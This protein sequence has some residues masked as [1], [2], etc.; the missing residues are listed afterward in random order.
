VFCTLILDNFKAFGKRQVIPLAP[1]TLIFGANSAGKS[2]ILQSLLVLKQTL[3]ES[4]ST[5]TRL[6]PRGSLV[7][8]GSI[9][10]MVF[11]HDINRTIEITPLLRTFSPEKKD[12][13]APIGAGF[14]F[15]HNDNDR[16]LRFGV[17]VYWGNQDAPA[18]T[19]NLV[20]NENADAANYSGFT[21]R[22]E[23]TKVN[24][25]HL[26]WKS[27]HTELL[28]GK[29]YLGYLQG[30]L[31]FVNGNKEAF[32]P[33]RLPTI[34]STFLGQRVRNL[35]EL[36]DGGKSELRRN[37]EQEIQR[38]SQLSLDELI[39]EVRSSKYIPGHVYPRNFLPI[40][41]FPLPSSEEEEY[42]PEWVL[43]RDAFIEQWL[44]DPMTLVFRTPSPNLFRLARNISLT[45]Q[46]A[47]SDIVYLGPLREYPERYYIYNDD[48]ARSVGKSGR[49]LPFL[50]FRKRRNIDHTNQVLKD[51]GLGY[52]LDIHAS[53]DPNMA[54]V[55]A[56]HLL[57]QRGV[58]V[59]MRDVGFGIGQV[60]PVIVQS[61]MSHEKVIL[62]EQPELHLHPRLQAELGS[63]FA[64]G[65]REPQQ[66]QFIIETHS[67]H[68]ILRLQKLIRTGQLK[69][70]DVS[71]I[72]VMKKEDG[73]YAYPLR[74]DED[75]D[76]IDAWPEGFFE[77]GYREIFG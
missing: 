30:A 75:G 9:R 17:G 53:E 73:S 45:L 15:R 33:W 77:E 69:P 72:Y 29:G 43:W 22:L 70:E 54:D 58:R 60:L 52:S 14:R 64:Q 59:S 20:H 66:N 1:I 76:F 68:L 16:Y 8:L 26:L 31:E 39:E 71:V 23:V 56:I 62:I 57:D 5:R 34:A 4:E 47:I 40:D 61:T 24:D 7:D 65:I 48:V 32:W 12:C 27:V 3:D 38:V 55:F 74:L 13:S 28:E 37:L 11:D 46:Q 21:D 49:Q 36:D 50:L 67:E 25:E 35:D 44:W 41:D 2:S 19:L 6:V 42:G 18:Y 10:D 63:L 51:F